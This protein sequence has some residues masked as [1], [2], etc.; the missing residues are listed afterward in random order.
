MAYAN[1]VSAYIAK[2]STFEDFKN[3]GEGIEE[4]WLKSNA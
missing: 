3:F 1:E 4:F 2:P